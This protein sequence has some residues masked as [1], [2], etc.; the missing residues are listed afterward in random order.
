MRGDGKGQ[1]RQAKIVQ[2]RS[3]PRLNLSSWF[4]NDRAAPEQPPQDGG[5]ASPRRRWSE[6]RGRLDPVGEQRYYTDVKCGL[7][8]EFV[9]DSRD[10]CLVLA[11]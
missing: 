3:P 6:R 5:I 11:G 4:D 10:R 1:G 8:S 7:R 9:S 2:N